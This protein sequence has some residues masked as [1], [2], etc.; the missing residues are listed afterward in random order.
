MVSDRLQRIRHKKER[1][2]KH[3]LDLQLALKVFRD[4]SPYEVVRD[5][6]THMG[7]FV[8]RVAKVEPTP[9]N[10]ML[11]AGDAI[12]NLRSTLDHLIWQLVKANGQPT[13]RHL[14]YPI[15][16]D[17]ESYVAGVNG[18]IQGV[19]AGVANVI[20]GTN[21]YKGGNDQF[22]LLDKLNNIDK[23]RVLIGTGWFFENVQVGSS[24]PWGEAVASGYVA[25]AKHFTVQPVNRSRP[26]K[27]GDVL[28]TTGV[29]LGEKVKF[30]LEVAFD[31]PQVVRGE[32]VL[33]TIK[34]FASLVDQTINQL[35]PFL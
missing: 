24:A 7:E 32:A 23:H 29:D 13:N 1:A 16:P 35:T 14:G 4:S 10:V 6:Q 11:I 2:E 27:A 17:H 22:W 34:G 5:S 18:K 28:H 33:E 12:Q 30:G 8:Y 26:L 21:P 19:V 20:D 25:T 15:F 3:I 9:P 31:E